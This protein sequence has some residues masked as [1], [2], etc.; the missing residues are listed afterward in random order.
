MS[1]T[2]CRPSKR[3]KTAGHLRHNHRIS[4]KTAIFRPDETQTSQS[5]PSRA[6][7][8]SYHHPLLLTSPPA[9]TA[10][11]S[12]FNTVI[13]ARNMPWRKTFRP[14]TTLSRTDLARRAYE[15]W[16]SEVMLQQTR[17]Q[18]VIGYWTRWM[19]RWPSLRDLAAAGEADVLAA[20]QGLGYYSRAR[21]V[22]EAARTVC[23]ANP[24]CVLPGTV[25]E[26]IKLPGL[27]RYTA[28]AIAAIVFGVPAP[29][30]DGNVLRVLSRQLGV[31]GDVKGDKRVIELLWDA[32]EELVKAVAGDGEEPGL[33]GQ[34]LMEL[35]STICTPY[36]NCYACPISGTCRAYSEGV[37]SYKGVQLVGT[38]E[39]IEDLCTLCAPFEE[40]REVDIAE[41]TDNERPTAPSN[42]DGR[43]SRFFAEKQGIKSPAKP[44]EQDMRSLASIVN[45][46]RKFPL[47][48]P[49]K[50]LRAEETLV[51]AI[52]R[53]SDGRYLIHQRPDKGLLAGLWELPSHILSNEST[54]EARK[55]SAEAYVAK[56][57]GKGQVPPMHAG[58]I[59]TI[60]W[61]FSHLKLQMHVHF[62][63]VED[64]KGSPRL[65]PRERWATAS[66]IDAESMG[67]G[68]K[69]CWSLVKGVM[70]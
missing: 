22:L 53:V 45:H 43:L 48:K 21:R 65:G 66:N 40:A 37:A 4:G 15:V 35:G 31:L 67:T 27:G 23:A 59:G 6:H 29:M 24:D 16:I 19:A 42:S 61:V 63:N 12:W 14:P 60:P 69:K 33:W 44:R 25:E 62:F 7:P 34:A 26:L 13:T 47:K 49:K 2:E 38:G 3:R 41:K 52:R 46:A 17:V 8:P 28:G 39:D 18:T 55:A 1:N 51:C 54:P 30:V 32:A 11:L 20:W 56:L 9:R 64:D 36:P 5:L 58:E 68:M 70:K 10:L 57:V 50:Q